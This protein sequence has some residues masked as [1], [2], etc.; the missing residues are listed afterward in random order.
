VF[1]QT[2]EEVVT[3]EG[4]VQ[5][6]AALLCVLLDEREQCPPVEP[7]GDVVECP[8]SYD[9]VVFDGLPVLV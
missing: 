1:R 3:D 5:R 4:A 8:A 9:E 7:F 6:G 2:P